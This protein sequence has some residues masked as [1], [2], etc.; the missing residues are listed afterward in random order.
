MEGDDILGRFYRVQT[1]GLV[2]PNT[3]GLEHTQVEERTR[4]VL[5]SLCTQPSHLPT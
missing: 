2:N 5:G 3:F 1:K 4:G